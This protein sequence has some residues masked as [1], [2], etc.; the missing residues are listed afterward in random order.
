MQG[1]DLVNSLVSIL[2]RL[3]KYPV[4]LVANIETMFH[5]I[6]IRPGDRN[7]LR[8][9]WWPAG[10]LSKS[11]ATYRKK[12]YIFGAT[13]SPSCAAF[14]LRQTAVDFCGDYKAMISTTIEQNFYGDDCLL[15]VP[16]V[17]MAFEMVEGLTSILRNAGFKL[18]K[19]ISNSQE[20][21]DSIPE[22]ERLE[23]LRVGALI[24]NMN[25]RALGVM[26]DINSDSF[27][28]DGYLPWTP[29]TK[30]GLLSTMNL[31]FDP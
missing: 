28:F 6:K 7:S 26:W 1:P 29:C 8:F 2:T 11:P 13:S 18:T 9:L 30:R 15:S 20:I 5:Q 27:W 21:I 19:W 17:V 24:G 25:E 10:D 4:T 22:P 12:V 16:N 14:A 31:L 23:T 3:R